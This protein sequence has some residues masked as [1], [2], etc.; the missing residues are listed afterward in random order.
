VLIFDEVFVGF[1]LAAGGAQEYFG[2]RADLVTYGKTLGGGLPVGV[3]CGPSKFMQRYRE[4]RPADIC[5][6][7]GTFAAHPY[8]MG[9]MHEF[10][11]FLGTEPARRLYADLDDVWDARAE[12]LNARLAAAG[13]PVRVANLGTIWTV[14]Y[15]QASRYNWLLQ[16][17]LR[18][19]GLHLPWIGTGRFIFSLDYTPADFADVADRFVAAALAMQDDGWWW[20]DARLTE[21]AIRRRVFAEL[22]QSWWR[23]C[24]GSISSPRRSA[25]GAR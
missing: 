6:A 21:Q 12:A 7:R 14:C 4:D 13:L 2:V 10:L 11:Q 24:I 16:F 5:F 8:V 3:V 23:A 17:Y 15:T 1:R 9:A 18:L 20:R 22:R 19:E 25:S